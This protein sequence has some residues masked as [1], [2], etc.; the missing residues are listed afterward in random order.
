MHNLIRKKN[1][2][3]EKASEKPNRGTYYK[4][5]EEYSTNVSHEKQGKSEKMLQTND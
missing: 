4:I 5:P 2:S 3:H 1:Y